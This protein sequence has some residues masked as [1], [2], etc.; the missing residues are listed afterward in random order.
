[1]TQIDCKQARRLVEPYITGV[2]DRP[3]RESLAGHLNTCAECRA[4]LEEKERWQVG[5]G[6]GV[7][8]ATRAHLPL[9]ARVRA[10][11]RR[12]SA[13]LVYGSPKRQPSGFALGFLPRRF[14]TVGLLSMVMMGCGWAALGS[15]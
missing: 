12:D 5:V 14:A 6:E 15:Y 11:L 7:D 13:A 8:R 2:L 1:M 4:L 9:R 3:D 10:R